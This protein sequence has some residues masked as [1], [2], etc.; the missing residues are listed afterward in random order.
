MRQLAMRLAAACVMILRCAGIVSA[1]GPITLTVTTPAAAQ[2]IG[3]LNV[4]LGRVDELLR[5]GNYPAALIEA[6]KLE[7]ISKTRFGTSHVN[8]AVALG[9]LAIVYLEQ[10]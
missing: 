8:Y 4:I 5:A 1:A 3:D 9:R 2:Q 10:G 6:Q 7:A